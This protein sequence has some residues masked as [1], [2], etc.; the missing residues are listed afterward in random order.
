[1]GISI[2]QLIILALPIVLLIPLVLV[3]LSDRSQGGCQA[4][5]GHPGPV[6][7]LDWL[8]H[9][10]HCHPETGKQTSANT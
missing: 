9:F 7:L 5:M 8:C 2:W 1:M 3:A 4:R 6:H 10:P